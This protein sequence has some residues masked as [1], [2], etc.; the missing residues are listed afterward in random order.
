MVEIQQ[1]HHFFTFKSKTESMIS[2]FIYHLSFIYDISFLVDFHLPCISS[3]YSLKSYL[4]YFVIINTFLPTPFKW[5]P[6]IL[7]QLTDNV[8]NAFIDRQT[9]WWQTEME[10][11]DCPYRYR[12]CWFNKMWTELASI[13][14]TFKQ[15]KLSVTPKKVRKSNRQLR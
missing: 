10:Q 5:W 9:L 8:I 7:L 11:A 1:E 6:V 15:I 4:S 13:F 2:D 12:V 3:F 14:F